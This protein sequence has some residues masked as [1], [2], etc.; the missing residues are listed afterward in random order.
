MFGSNFNERKHGVEVG[1]STKGEEASVFGV[2]HHG[3]GRETDKTK[4]Q[5]TSIF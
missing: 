1:K 2:D 5:K 3:V 4:K